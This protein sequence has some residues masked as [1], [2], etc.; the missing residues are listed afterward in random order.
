M[1]TLKKF[2]RENNNEDFWNDI[3]KD[4]DDIEEQLI[5]YI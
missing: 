4:N 5:D 2:L 3:N 1:K